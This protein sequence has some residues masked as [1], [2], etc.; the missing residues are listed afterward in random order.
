MGRMR[1]EPLN[2]TL[3][4]DLDDTRTRNRQLGRSTTTSGDSHA[5]GPLV[6]AVPYKIEVVLTDK[7]I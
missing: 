4:F 6:E 3:F 5:S 7:G 1:D 2:E